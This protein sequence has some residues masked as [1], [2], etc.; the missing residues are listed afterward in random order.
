MD[1]SA[2]ESRVKALETSLDS[3]EGLITIATFLVVVGLIVEYWFPFRELIEAVKK[4]PP[5]PWGKVAEMI[6]GVLV[7]VGVAGELWFQ[8][9]ASNVQTVIRSD[10]HQIEAILNKEAGDA[11]K[12]AGK[13]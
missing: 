2:L 5:F 9:R 8:S 1:L 13:A 11:R 6:G 7:T 10:T 3:L 12:D 4:R